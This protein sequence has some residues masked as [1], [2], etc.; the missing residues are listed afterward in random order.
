MGRLI[1]VSN[2]LPF[3]LSAEDG[4]FRFKPSSG[5]LVTALE[6][7]L[8]SLNSEE[9]PENKSFFDGLITGILGLLG[10]KE[11]DSS[12]VWVGWS[13][14]FIEEKQRRSL[15]DAVCANSLAGASVHLGG[16]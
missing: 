2:R 5:G 4:A 9:A 8:E 12:R 15:A 13:G 1:V 14:A 7:Y 11:T 6:G 16:G 3:T 10:R